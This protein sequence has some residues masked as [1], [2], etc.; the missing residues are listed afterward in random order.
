[1][2]SP[3]TIQI[4]VNDT[5]DVTESVL[6]A[7]TRFELVASST[8]G[9]GRVVLKDPNKVLM[10]ATGDEISLIVDGIRLWG[11][12]MM[13]KGEGH[14]FPVVDTS[15]LDRVHDLQ[16]S[17]NAV[18]YNIWMDKRV[19]RDPSNY[20]RIAQLGPGKMGAVLRQAIP[21]YMDVPPGLDY[22]THVEDTNVDWSD[23]NGGPAPLLQQ[24]RYW[25][26][27]LDKMAMQGGFEWR[28]DANKALHFHALENLVAP[29]GFVD[30]NPNGVT[31]IGF[32]EGT[33][34][35]DGMQ[36]VTDA[37][38]WGGHLLQLE[39]APLDQAPVFARYPS[40]PANTTTARGQILTAERE[41]AA[42][43][44]ITQYGRWQRA[45]LRINEDGFFEQEDVLLR[46]AAIVSGPDVG[47]NEITGLDVGLNRPVWQVS[48]SWFA[49]D[50]PGK[51]H[52]MPGMIVPLVFW[53]MGVDD[54]HPLALYLPLRTL[55]ISFPTL[56]PRLEG[57]EP[58][59]YVRFDGEFGI[60]YSD[61]RYLWR[62]LRARSQNPQTILAS[63]GQTATSTVPGALGGFFPIE[64]P[65][66][67]TTVF[68]LPFSY[69]AGTTEVYINGLLQ[70]PRYEYI[71]SS[72]SLGK[73]TFAQPPFPDDTI[74]VVCRTGAG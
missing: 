20:L 49:H 64:P 29:W 67:V 11:G 38:V 60:S 9:T 66:S 40:P 22:T 73:I 4:L 63:V 35:E 14:F 25:R 61:T 18:D 26:E 71:E 28:I 3:S 33:I 70:R 19:F 6:Y 44:R 57:D 36:M 45:E 39:E 48:L 51:Q 1:M 34:R 2:P 23:G 47:T 74:W 58:Q 21:N 69:L 31:S 12:L 41:Q 50:V 5:E 37:L 8:P 52:L 7:Q 62:F 43:D 53:T 32:R 42:I 46:A 17:L 15:D 59:T 27:G 54:Q 72:P 13:D 65:D 68:T 56:P 10:F 16:W 55:N 24:G 30:H